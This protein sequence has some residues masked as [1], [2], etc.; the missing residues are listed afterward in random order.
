MTHQPKRFNL[1]IEETLPDNFDETPTHDH[2]N[3]SDLPE[4]FDSRQ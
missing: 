2:I 3:I 4:N 1:V